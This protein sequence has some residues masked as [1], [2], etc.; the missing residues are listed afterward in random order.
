[1]TQVWVTD[2]EDDDFEI[3]VDA[4][5]GDDLDDDDDEFA[6]DDEI[7]EDG[8]GLDEDVSADGT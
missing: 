5:G 3:L 2:P 7:A 6:D 8:E 1:M 4:D